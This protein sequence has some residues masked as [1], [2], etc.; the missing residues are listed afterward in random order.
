MAEPPPVTIEPGPA[1]ETPEED[2]PVK[3]RSV[4]TISNIDLLMGD[5]EEDEAAG[6]TP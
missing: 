3:V 4:E 5:V 6:R 1:A 2:E